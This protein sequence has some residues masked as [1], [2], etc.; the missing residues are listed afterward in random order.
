MAPV[1][2]DDVSGKLFLGGVS[3]STTEEGLSSYF[4][5]YGKL[6]DSCVLR[7]KTGHPRGF[8]FVQYEDPSVVEKVLAETHVLDGKTLDIKK[9]ISRKDAPRGSSSGSTRIQSKKIFVGG[10]DTSVTTKELEEYFEKFGEITDAVVMFDKTTNRSRGF[11]FIT[12]SSAQSVKDVLRDN[13]EIKGKFIEVK[14]AEPRESDV[15]RPGGGRF[16]R[17][18]DRDRG[19][20]RDRDR[21]YRDRGD[22]DAY[23]SRDSAYNQ[24]YRGGSAYRQEYAPPSGSFGGGGAA[25]FAGS[26]YGGGYGSGMGMGAGTAGFGSSVFQGGAGF[27]SSLGG[28]AGFGSA[29]TS[30]GASWYGNEPS[31]FGVSGGS[32]GF[33]ATPSTS[34]YSGFGTS[35]G[36]GGGLGASSSLGTALAYGSGGLSGGYAS[37][38]SV[39]YNSQVGMGNSFVSGYG[40]AT[41]TSI[42]SARMDRSFRPY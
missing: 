6:I 28:S 17:D 39:G 34:N 25:G 27:G 21:G 16:D 12:Y 40:P 31:K 42:Q 5:K 8:G 1:D 3:R 41:Q 23:S 7:D 36:L 4:E 30:N 26:V 11:G 35:S 37:T 22:R 9:A 15:G 38:P 29:V 13:H 18:R 24:E 2:R 20:D 32:A 14:P 19:R 33:V 10:L